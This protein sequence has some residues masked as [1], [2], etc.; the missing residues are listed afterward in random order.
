MKNL[1]D[2][3]WVPLDLPP[4]PKD[5]TLENI[6]SLY[7]YQPRLTEEQR[8]DLM[9]KKEHHQ[10]AWDCFHMR[11][12]TTEVLRP[13]YNQVSDIEWEWADKAKSRCPGI[14]SYIEK[15][16]PFKNIKY[17]TAISSIGSV[18]LHLD[19]KEDI[20]QEEK[21]FYKSN[22]PCFYRFVLD[23][24]INE[25]SFYVYTKTL[26]KIYCKFPKGAP[27]W[28][29]GSY[30]CAHGNDEEIPFQKLLMYV[31]GDLDIEK[32]QSLIERSYNKY[33]DYAI[34]RDYVA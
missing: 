16:L 30:S 7:T 26:G 25:N 29:M 8:E 6:K 18:P 2:I 28:V 21:D 5:L 14:I 24:T 17:V 34:V 20:P 4:V 9:K 31:M 33:R 3:L 10:Y 11:L 19:L 12:P 27:G 15:E 22:D 13:Y 23:G 1:N 32:H